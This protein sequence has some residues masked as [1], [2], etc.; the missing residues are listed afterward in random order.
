MHEVHPR[1][2]TSLETRSMQTNPVR[3]GELRRIAVQVLAALAAGA[4]GGYLAALLRPHP[5]A[6]WASDYQAPHPASLVSDD[7]GDLGP[8]T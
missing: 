3:T 6:A 8:A 5:S 2:S 1:D 7:G 4:L